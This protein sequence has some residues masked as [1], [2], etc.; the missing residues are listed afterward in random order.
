LAAQD[1]A[2]A[3]GATS[4]PLAQPQGE[5]GVHSIGRF[6][7]KNAEKHKKSAAAALWF[8]RFSLLLHPITK[9][10]CY[11]CLSQCKNQYRIKRR[12]SSP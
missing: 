10:I 11:D 9:D 8:R 2:I 7:G 1:A 4:A 12:G 3:D 6:F 5:I